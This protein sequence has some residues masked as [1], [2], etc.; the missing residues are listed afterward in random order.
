MRRLAF[1]V[2]FLV[3][4]VGAMQWLFQGFSTAWEPRLRAYLADSA[5]NA[6]QAKVSIDSIVP[7]FFHRIRLVNVQIV[8][9]SGV[10]L[11]QAGEIELTISLIDLPRAILL[12]HG[13]E[14][15]GLVLVKNPW[16]K[17]SRE[18]LAKR[19]ARHRSS[20]SWPPWFT[21][22]W[23]GGTFQW[24]D[25][26]APHGTWTLYQTHGTFRIR[27]P[28]TT[29]V[30]A[31]TVEQARSVRLEYRS[32]GQRWNAR[33]RLAEADCASV[34]ALTRSLT[35]RNMIPQNWSARGTFDFE[36]QASGRRPPARG[37]DWLHFLDEARVTFLRPEAARQTDNPSI[38]LTGT[39]TY[40]KGVVASPNLTVECPWFGGT[41][42]LE[43]DLRQIRFHP[44]IDVNAR[45]ASGRI[46]PASPSGRHW[47]FQDAVIHTRYVNDH[48]ELIQ[49]SFH[50]LDGQVSAKGT[51]GPSM[52]D[53][54]I[55]AENVS[56][57]ALA[58]NHDGKVLQGRVNASCS[59][60]GPAGQRQMA[61]SWWLDGLRW[62]T[63]SIGNAQGDFEISADQFQAE[64]K[65]DN[66]RFRFSTEGSVSD[67]DLSLDRLEVHLPDGASFSADAGLN[68]VTHHLQGIF[69]A[70]N[71]DF[72]SDIPVGAASQSP[73][74]GRL[75]IH[76][77]LT[78]TSEQVTVKGSIRSPQLT[79]GSQTLGK[80][81][82]S[83]LW[84][85]AH[86]E[87]PS[88]HIEPGVDGH[89][90][91]GEAV[92]QI[93]DSAWG[94]WSI[95]QGLVRAQVK[96]DH[97][98]ITECMLE[99]RDAALNFIGKASWPGQPHRPEHVM[100]EGHGRAREKD[101]DLWDIPFGLTGRL[102]SGPKGW[103]GTARLITQHPLLQKKSVDPL[104]AVLD[105]TPGRLA[106]ELHG[107]LSGTLTLQGT[108]ESPQG[109]LALHLKNGRYRA[110]EFSTDLSG[111]WGPDGVKPLS[112]KGH[113]KSGGDFQFSGLV[114]PDR[115]TQGTLQ[116][117]GFNV[118]PL[119]ESLGFPKPIEGM[120]A[121]T[122]T[123][124][125][126][127]SH[128]TISGHLGGGPFSY[129]GPKDTPIRIEDLSMDMTLA[130]LDRDP[131]IE[132]V[133][134]TEAQARTAEELIRF[135]SGS[136]IEFAGQR[137]A[138]LKLGT[139]VRNLHL[140]LFTLF[141]GLNLDGTWQVKSDSFAIQARAHTQQLFINDYELEEGL[142]LVDYYN[143][144]LKFPPP[145]D[146]PPLITGI[147]DFHKAPQ[148][149]FTDFFISGKDRQGLELSGDIGPTLW[150]FQMAGHGLD[151]GILGELAGFPYPMGGAAD[152]QVRG[153]GNPAH[154]HVEGS[155]DLRRGT[156]FGLAFRT[157]SASFIWQD[158]R[159]S[160]TRL[161]LSDP[162]H[163]TLEGAGVFPLVS[164]DKT[165]G[166]DHSID[167]S[168]RLIDSNLS[169][170]QSCMPEVKQ[171]KG[172][173]DGLLQI[174]GTLEAPSLH[175]SLRVANGDVVGAHYFRQLHNAALSID[176]EGDRVIIRDLRGRSGDGEFRGSGTI[177]LSGFVPSI[178]DLKMDVVSSK[179]VEVQVPE[180]AIPESPLAKRFRFLTSASR[181]DV[182][183]HMTLRGPAEAPVFSGTGIISNGHFTFP[184][185]HRNPPN[186]AVME[187][188]RRITWD[189][190]LRFQD[191][192]WFDNEL[193]QANVTGNL[194]LKGPSDKLRVDGGLDINDGKISYLG[195]QFDVRQARYDVRSE[196]S[197][198][199]IVNT[200][201]VR[202]VAESQIQA[203]DTV[204]GVSG[205]SG[206]SRMSVND[207]I[208]L[209]IDYAP[210]DQIKP[211]LTS[212]ANPTLSQEK[213]LARVTQTDI[214]NLT[215]QEQTSL[216]QKQIVSLIDSSLATPLAQNVLKKTGLADRVRVQ[217]IFDPNIATVQDLN[218]AAATQQPSSAVNLFA[219]TKYTIEKDLSNRLSL[220]YGIRFVPSATSV[221][222]ELQQQQK[223]DL[224]SDVQLSYR[225]FK[226]VYLK[227]DFDLPTSNPSV[228]PERK[229]TI[230]PRWRFGWWGNTN[231]DKLP[232]KR[233]SSQ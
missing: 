182:R 218:A 32:L 204:S 226:N 33:M 170:L 111:H 141:G 230:E 198:E 233:D 18:A 104:E 142:V 158:A 191:G 216:Y 217:H 219:N 71:I 205:A 22:A 26:N 45:L 227:G 25:P 74:H 169:L 41:G 190:D 95:H 151:M 145:A 35:K 51:L 129:G 209:N 56:L 165:R 42:Q 17:I 177:T 75:D 60:K 119:G 94:Q 109:E 188:F 127:L 73:V 207:T 47:P 164:K 184:P 29:F 44:Q 208:T 115:R 82:A 159:I 166:Q 76:G 192:A 172:P 231:Q 30:M 6:L 118:H 183:G 40:K 120:A 150:D 154:P 161:S 225:W 67:Q 178:Y 211:R 79:L 186:P 63:S 34:L 220:G 174:K 28:Q 107:N 77:R 98:A 131:S 14:A 43:M 212:A 88:F 69:E 93:K 135:Q 222:P 210:V 199:S 52:S 117:S 37:E 144:V 181:A 185:S 124:N 57:A 87:I 78:G 148:L 10:P 130:P 20:S 89:Y 12:R 58:N 201:Y 113:L 143:G 66:S 53:L 80:T 152:V 155:V 179:G 171:A 99:T 13:Y 39:L 157:G 133:T 61:G 224:I 189:V 5:G 202:G 116:L 49:N 103:S 140:G 100:L 180:L 64:A 86:L 19:T 9:P 126:P 36:A 96:P 167:F 48:W 228:V 102:D 139:E 153:T 194:K 123:L 92:L 68:R 213:I 112:V 215:P 176:F 8:E 27:G 128:L 163:Y 83:F 24:M 81:T 1:T 65:S 7:S 200:P 90:T 121:A 147:I 175:G 214:E 136:Y 206:G 38:G 105:W 4:F 125:G 46:G 149:K 196:S 72:P 156:A 173:V 85:P 162:G 108:A 50:F 168:V 2:I 31:G 232:K 11:F 16:I 203:V 122:L 114:T 84:N 229:V 15:I 110:F 195:I 223:L 3:G 106:C 193:V 134:V 97:V 187:W 23:E 221:D 160:F 132:H 137:P 54:S 197:G 70:A 59:L 55:T 138:R 21:L 91:D 101:S 146:A 62:G